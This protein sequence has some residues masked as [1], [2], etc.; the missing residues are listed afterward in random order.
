MHVSMASMAL[1]AG[2]HKGRG[3]IHTLVHIRS[4]LSAEAGTRASVDLRVCSMLQCA[5]HVCTYACI[6]PGARR[7]AHSR[8]MATDCVLNCDGLCLE[9]SQPVAGTE[10]CVHSHECLVLPHA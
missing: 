3:G 8:L 4:G 9:A 10:L 7:L 5:A 6:G 1:P 2:N